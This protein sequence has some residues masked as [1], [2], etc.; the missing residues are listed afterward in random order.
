MKIRWE[1]NI[2]S[3]NHNSP[4]DQQQYMYFRALWFQT[5]QGK[6]TLSQN[7][8][9]KVLIIFTNN[10]MVYLSD[11]RP[12]HL[13]HDQR[14]MEALADAFLKVHADASRFA[15]GVTK[16]EAYA[17]VLGSAKGLMDGQR[18]WVWYAQ[19]SMVWAFLHSQDRIL[20]FTTMQHQECW[21]TKPTSNSNLANAASLL[22]H[23][24]KSMGFPSDRVNWAGTLQHK[25]DSP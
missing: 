16:S 9:P 22:W 13:L 21:L 3:K 7:W 20:H 23:A 15:D 4:D 10:N 1:L 5:T 2:K 11:L 6:Q 18:N 25:I 17:Q 24:Y 12:E 8:S 19:F 14:S